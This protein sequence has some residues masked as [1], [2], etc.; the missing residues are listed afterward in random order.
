MAV[1]SLGKQYSMLAKVEHD[2]LKVIR[3][4]TKEIE[5]IA[6]SGF[7]NGRVNV[8]ESLIAGHMLDVMMVAY[9]RQYKAR[10]TKRPLELDFSREVAKV[11]NQFDLEI[12]N[13][14]NA[15]WS[16][17]G[18]KATAAAKDWNTKINNELGKITA[19]GWSTRSSRIAL[20]AALHRMGLAPSNHGIVETLVRTHAQVAFNAAQYE[21][22][23]DDELIWGYRYSTVGDSRVR[24]EHRRL[25]GMVLRKDDP[26]LGV[27]WPPNGYNCRCALIELIDEEPVNI[28]PNA[29]LEV[30]PA[31][32]FNPGTLIR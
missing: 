17:A 3:K 26:L 29:T 7:R 15:F 21:I 13:I 9:M 20:R 27:L 5:R 23:K 1:I 31:F 18:P 30:D 6:L 8:P 32:T 12:P 24:E 16:W 25:D 10:A 2:S 14:R 22:N 11:A 19:Q 4:L 28:P